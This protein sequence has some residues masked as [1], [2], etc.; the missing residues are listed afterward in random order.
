[1][2]R[3]AHPHEFWG[4][5]CVGGPSFGCEAVALI[6]MRSAR[7]GRDP[8]GEIGANFDCVKEVVG[9]EAAGEGERGATVGRSSRYQRGET[10]GAIAVTGAEEMFYERS[11]S[12]SVE[13]DERVAGETGGD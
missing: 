10:A 5:R 1:M 12:V 8:C 11:Q 2:F 6:E 4:G 3:D 13:I 7:C 9:A